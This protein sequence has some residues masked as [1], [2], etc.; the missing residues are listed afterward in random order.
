M[1]SPSPSSLAQPIDGTLADIIDGGGWVD[2][3]Q[4][5]LTPHGG[6]VRMLGLVAD[7]CQIHPD[8]VHDTKVIHAAYRACEGH[9]AFN[10]NPGMVTDALGS[11]IHTC[12]RPDALLMVGAIA[13]T[14]GQRAG[15]M[16]SFHDLAAR[17]HGDWIDQV[18]QQSDLAYQL[19]YV[20]AALARPGEHQTVHPE[21]HRTC[22]A[23]LRSDVLRA[24]VD[25]R[26]IDP[27]EQ[28]DPQAIQRVETQR[29]HSW[30]NAWRLA[31]CYE[32]PDQRIQTAAA[33]AFL[34]ASAYQRF[35]V[36]NSR[37]GCDNTILNDRGNACVVD[38]VLDGRATCAVALPGPCGDG[39]PSVGVP[40]TYH[41]VNARALVTQFSRALTIS[42]I[43][44]ASRMCA[45]RHAT[46][47]MMQADVQ[48][49]TSD[50]QQHLKHV[51]VRDL[52]T[53]L[54]PPWSHQQV[55][56]QRPAVH[57]I[58]PAL[59][60]IMEADPDQLIDEHH[61]LAT[62]LVRAQMKTGVCLVKPWVPGSSSRTRRLLD[63]NQRHYVTL[64]DIMEIVA[65]RPWIGK[66]VRKVADQSTIKVNMLPILRIDPTRGDPD[67]IAAGI[68]HVRHPVDWGRTPAER[69]T[70]AQVS[71]A[72]WYCFDQPGHQHTGHWF[73]VDEDVDLLG[74]AN[75]NTD[76]V[77][78][79]WY[80]WA[81]TYGE[82]MLPFV[83]AALAS[84]T[85][86][87]EQSQRR[88][89]AME[90]ILK[91]GDARMQRALEQVAT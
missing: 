27:C 49:A 22:T 64:S 40:S 79:V 1:P 51:I 69:F 14:G 9:G 62:M 52:P 39:A 36:N 91:S 15:A 82:D 66:V 16:A 83:L 43:A 89:R 33:Q 78:G 70:N 54:V 48:P 63:L 71:M 7:H 23:I 42:T 72:S 77:D 41:E 76:Q 19:G 26:P 47:M 31:D 56:V 34:D 75:P 68:P 17:R 88:S 84:G 87:G 90:R 12:D 37:G 20:L 81:T 80:R 11:L 21:A 46:R 86:L 38:A 59:R 50:L 53:D 28:H 60:T 5:E 58:D 67:G 13:L 32:S 57:I 35:F 61:H 74:M 8:A 65:Q 45:A 29:A 4:R 85:A 24:H 6:H 30:M 2:R 3:I 10:V 18:R 25:Q 44:T 55:S 73:Q